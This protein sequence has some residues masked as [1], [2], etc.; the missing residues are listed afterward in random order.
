MDNYPMGVD[1]SHPYF[2][3]D[4]DPPR[5]KRCGMELDEEWSFC[6]WCGEKVEED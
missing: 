2:N 1:G 3:Q 5:C 6:P 4:Y